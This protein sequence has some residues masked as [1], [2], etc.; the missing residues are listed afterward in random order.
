MVMA[1][2]WNVELEMCADPERGW[3]HPA[4]RPRHTQTVM[5]DGRIRN[6][7]TALRYRIVNPPKGWR[8]RSLTP[9]EAA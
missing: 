3:M 5:V 9:K 1:R 8:I 4:D 2:P 6:A 7:D